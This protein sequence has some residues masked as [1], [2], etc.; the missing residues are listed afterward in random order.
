MGEWELGCPSQSVRGA[1]QSGVDHS[2]LATAVACVSKGEGGGRTVSSDPSWSL[3]VTWTRATNFRERMW[4]HA[5]SYYGMEE[6]L[7][8]YLWL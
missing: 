3:H 5:S 8:V 7:R 4:F 2:D 1:S 6:W